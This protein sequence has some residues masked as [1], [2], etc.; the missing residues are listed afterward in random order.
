MAGHF[1]VR[2]VSRDNERVLAVLLVG[3]KHAGF[4]FL[5][6]TELNQ[7]RLQLDAPQP[8]GSKSKQS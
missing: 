4:F 3:G 1:Q 5:S 7:L 2:E 8:V 6:P